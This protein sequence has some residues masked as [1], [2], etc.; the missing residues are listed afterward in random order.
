MLCESRVFKSEEEINYMRLANRISSEAHI[1]CMRKVRPG[2]RESGLEA[3]FRGYCMLKYN[4]RVTAYPC[5]CACGPNPATLHYFNNTDL[6]P[7]VM[8]CL[9]DMGHSVH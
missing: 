5:V 7:D 8:M 1:E 6:L 3:I 2:M 4:C 9:T